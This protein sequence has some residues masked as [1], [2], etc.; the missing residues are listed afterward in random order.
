MEN[1]ALVRQSPNI[2]MTDPWIAP[3]KVPIIMFIVGFE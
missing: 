2:G 1:N 3:I